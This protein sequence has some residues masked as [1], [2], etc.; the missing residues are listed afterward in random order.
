MRET[1][2]WS[3]S[4]V[5]GRSPYPWICEEIGLELGSYLE[6]QV[7]NGMIYLKP[8]KLVSP[9]DADQRLEEILSRVKYTG[10]VDNFKE[11]SRKERWPI[12]EL[13]NKSQQSQG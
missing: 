10:V 1:L 2:P 8:V 6:A 5:A 9:A 13:Q 12:S 3:R 11:A 4:F 7:S